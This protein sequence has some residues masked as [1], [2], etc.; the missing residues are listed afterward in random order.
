MTAPNLLESSEQAELYLRGSGTLLA[1]WEE[2]ARGAAAVFP[3]EPERAVRNNALFERDLGTG[4]RSAALDA[5]EAVYAAVG[6]RDLG[7]ILGYVRS[8][9]ETDDE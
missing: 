7:R 5:M 2:Y 1:S 6:F 9:K 3:R 8:G 4:G